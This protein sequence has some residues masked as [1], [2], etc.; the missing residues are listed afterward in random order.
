ML[1]YRISKMRANLQA[2]QQRRKLEQAQAQHQEADTCQCPA[3][4]LRRALTS[5]NVPGVTVLDVQRVEATA[6][7]SDETDTTTKH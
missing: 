7:S 5:L 2:A 1:L 6:A 3:C 4:L